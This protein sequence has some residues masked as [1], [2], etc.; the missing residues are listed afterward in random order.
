LVHAETLKKIAHEAELAT[1][2]N[3]L[4]AALTLWRQ[5][6]DLLPPDSR[7][8]EVIQQKIV[9]L[10]QKLDAGTAPQEQRDGDGKKSNAGLIGAIG[11]ALLFLVTKG[12]FLLMGLSKAGTFFSMLAAFGVYWTVWGWQFALGFVLCIYIHEMGHVAA[13][14][15]YGIPATPPMFIPGLGAFIRS[16]QYP[17]TPGEDAYV[18]LAGP[19]WGL[20]ATVIT[21]ALFL[22]TNNK[23]FAA[24][25]HISAMINFF[26]LTPIGSLDGGRGF[27][28]LTG[29]Q[30][31]IAILSVG[32]AWYYTHE[33]LVL[34]VLVFAIYRLFTRDKPEKPDHSAL[35]K[36][37]VLVAAL[38]WLSSIT[39]PLARVGRAAPPPANSKAAGTTQDAAET[40]EDGDE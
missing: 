21:Y 1:S 9:A 32:A 5:A 19:I 15:R 7:Q 39:Q 11:T 18:G 17:A 6:I 3:D 40:S 36:Y 33:G 26:N 13:L 24:L 30:R 10:S 37:V 28:A 31:F 25:T 38:I 27:R 8:Y 16:K 23:L 4:T 29:P 2:S 35:A 20:G 12:K 34:F 22:Y 14:R